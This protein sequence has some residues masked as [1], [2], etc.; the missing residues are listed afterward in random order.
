MCH[1][2]KPIYSLKQAPRA[3]Y[4]SLKQYLIDSGFIPSLAD[5][6][7]FIQAIGNTLT[8]ILVYI[9]D[10]IIIGNNDNRITQV[11]MD[12]ATRFSIK[13]PTDLHYFLG[14]D[15]TCTS[16]RLHLKQRKYIADLLAKHNMLDAKP[17]STPLH[18]AS[19]YRSLV[20][21]FQYLAFTRPDLSY[22]VNRLSQFMHRPTQEHWK[23]A[24]RVLRYLTG[25][26]T[27]GITLHK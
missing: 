17:V 26:Q 1:L 9:D 14:V 4:I 2:R 16:T 15:V 11:L 20:G 25:T 19:Q 13:Y 12:L 23:A 21:S 27:H 8:Y 5:T 10:I 6:S 24:K 22:A 3:W 7:L 18:D